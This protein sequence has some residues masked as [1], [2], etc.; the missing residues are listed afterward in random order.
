MRRSVAVFAALIVTGCIS[1]TMD[2]WIGHT[3]QELILS[4]GPPQQRVSDGSDGTVLIYSSYVTTGTAP[5][6]LIPTSSG[7][8]I[9]TPPQTYGHQRVRMF[10]IRADGTIYSWRAQ[11]L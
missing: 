11:G 6:E 8:A 4:W 3:E 1:S 9:Y 2:P 7:G 5:G 10:Y